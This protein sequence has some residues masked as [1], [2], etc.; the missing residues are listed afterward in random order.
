M[1][2]EEWQKAKA[3]FPWTHEIEVNGLGGIIRLKD[4]KGKEVPLQTMV[5]VMER[6]TLHISKR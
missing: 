4:N 2:D 6:L 1:T 3:T 5:L